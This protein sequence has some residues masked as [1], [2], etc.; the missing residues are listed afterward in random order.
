[1]D[2][3]IL[4]QLEGL[5]KTFSEIKL[6]Y[7]FGSRARGKE[8]PTSDYDFAVYIDRRDRKRLFEIKF[9]LMD[10]ISR[11]LK[12]NKVDVI[13]LNMVKSPEL[14]YNCIKEGQ[15]I[16]EVEPFKVIVE[17]SIMTEYFDFKHMLRRYGLTRT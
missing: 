6:V 3:N 1:M 5:F 7:L 8:G 13:I 17:P 4:K 11:I 15:L 2:K 14:K 10:R 9:I 16:Y 12:T